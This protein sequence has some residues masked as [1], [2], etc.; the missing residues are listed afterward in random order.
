MESIK[1][2]SR[3]ILVRVLFIMLLTCLA[4]DAG[5]Y[6]LLQNVSIKTRMLLETYPSLPEIAASAALVQTA[7]NAFWPYFVPASLIFFILMGLILWLLLRRPV[8]R[9]MQAA[10]K[11]EKAVARP[12][13]REEAKEQADANK[14]IFVHLLSVMQ[15]EGRLLDFFSENLTQYPD[16]QIGAAVRNIHENCNKTLYKYLA[17]QAVLEQQEG[18][19]IT[20]DSNFDPNILKLIGNVTGQP[21]FK[22]TVRHRGWRARKIDLPTLSGRQDPAIIAPAEVEVG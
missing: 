14:R 9:R 2:V 12:R 4:I 19:Q 5:I 21:P 15:R 10:A 22:G 16:A 20:V 7:E 13:P 6:W 17:P 3:L 8:A 11:P 1:A 18:E